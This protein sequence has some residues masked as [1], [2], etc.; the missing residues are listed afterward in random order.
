MGILEFSNTQENQLTNRL[1][2]A[3]AARPG[4]EPTPRLF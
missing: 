2:P 3:V 1:M 4:F